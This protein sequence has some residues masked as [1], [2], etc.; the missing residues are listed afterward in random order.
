MPISKTRL[1]RLWRTIHYGVILVVSALLF[2]TLGLIVLEKTW[3]ED[4]EALWPKDAFFNGRIGTELLPLPVVQV[5]PILFP[6]HFGEG[7]QWVSRF[8]FYKASPNDL[9]P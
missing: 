6:E 5:L 8:G 3:Q 1:S 9:L 4:H 7:D 2:A